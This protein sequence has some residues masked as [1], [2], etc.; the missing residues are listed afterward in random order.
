MIMKLIGV[1]TAKATGM[2]IEGRRVMTAIRKT[3]A[4]GAVAVAPLGLVGDEQANPDVHGGLGKAVYAYPSEH[5][6][7]WRQARRDKGLGQID[8][9]LP[10]GSM[11]E[12]LT[13]QG[14]LESDVWVGD[15]LE[16][17][18]CT[19][20]VTDPR[21]PCFKFNATMGFSTAAKAMAQSG[22]CGFYLAVDKTGT[23]AAGETFRI[24]AGSRQMS[25]PASFAVKM[26]RA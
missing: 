4:S 10:F 3:A 18:N 12:N 17:P 13:L 26:R 16:F 24:I 5:Y 8:D 22:F 20:R 7:F 19:L 6:D 23:I 11:G 25:I 14:L 2:M 1:Q 9:S 21:E 15:V